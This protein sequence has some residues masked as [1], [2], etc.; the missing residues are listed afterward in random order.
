MKPGALKVSQ[1]EGWSLNAK[2]GQTPQYEIKVKGHLDGGWSE[3]FNGMD[4]QNL[5]GGEAVLCGPV[6]DQAA[7]YGILTKIR[8]IGLPLISIHAVQPEE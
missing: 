1:P 4:I 7:L 3:W 8:D 6:I 2:G 5:P